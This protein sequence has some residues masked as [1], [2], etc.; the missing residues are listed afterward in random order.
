[1]G[2]KDEEL[3]KI[4][5]YTEAPTAPYKVIGNVQAK[6]HATSAVSREPTLD[7]V[8]HKLREKALKMGA[9]SV[10]NVK[11]ERKKMDLVGWKPLTAKGQVATVEEGEAQLVLVICPECYARMPLKTNF[12]TECGANLKARK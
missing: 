11:Y 3:A 8:N 4:K 12:C 9:N 2:M 7:E 10:I 6:A 1:M 5:I